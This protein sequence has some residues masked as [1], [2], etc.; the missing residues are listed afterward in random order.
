MLLGQSPA[1]TTLTLNNADIDGGERNA[2]W[3]KDINQLTIKLTGN[4]KV[5]SKRPAITTNKPM[6]IM[7]GGTLNVES[8]DNCAIY[9]YKT[10]LT[11]ENCT[12][13][14]KGIWGIVGYDGNNGEN[15]IIRNA[16]VT[17]EGEGNEWHSIGEFATLTLD[18]CAITQPA[19]AVFDAS[20]RGVAL[21]GKLVKTTVKIEPKQ[22]ETYDLTIAGVKVTRGNCNDLSVIDGVSGMVKYDHATT[23]LT[24]DNADIDGGNEIAIYS[25]DV[26]HLTIKL[27]GNNKVI[28]NTTTITNNKPMTIT[29]GGTLDVESTKDCAIFANKTD[30]TIENCTVNAKGVQYGIAGYNGN[31]GEDLIIRNATVTAEGNGAQSIGDFATLTLDG[32]AITQPA[33]AAFDASLRGVAL[34]GELVKTSVKIEPRQ[35]ETYDLTIAGVKVTRDNCNDLSVIDGVSGTVTYD[36]ATSTLTLDNATIEAKGYSVDGIYAAIPVNIVVKGTINITSAQGNAVFLIK[37]STIT[38][39]GTLNATGMQTSGIEIRDLT[40][41]NCTVNA[42][43]TWGIAGRDGTVEKLTI[44]NAHITA[45]GKEGSIIDFKEITLENCAITQPTGAA[46]DASL[47]GV[48]LNGQLVNSKV[49]I[50]K[51]ATGISAVTTDVPIKK[52]G[53]YNLAGQRVGDSYKGIAIENGRKNLKK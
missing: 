11:I 29:G 37:T 16:T 17:A 53:T 48:A 45:E 31:S 7:G 39:D 5:I 8:I 13:N 32:C 38:G 42:K 51:G 9:A 14:A 2:I 36:P 19:G 18:G 41:E 6:T 25:K 50:T 34:N 20:L 10:D 27:I 3:S 46:Y 15:L 30:L 23:T 44:R 22:T 47:R 35:T 49:V 24:L 33:D 52:Q 43:G 12:V 28:A 21:N 1:T 26:N 40:I 4:N